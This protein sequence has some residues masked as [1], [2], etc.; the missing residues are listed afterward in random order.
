[1][2]LIIQIRIAQHNLEAAEKE[3][4]ATKGWAQDS[5]LAQLAEVFNLGK[6]TYNRHG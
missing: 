1:V 2:A 5:L 3:L 6:V 4:N